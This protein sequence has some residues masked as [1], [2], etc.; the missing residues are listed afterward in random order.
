MFIW[1]TGW[2]IGLPYDI[3]AQYL[4]LTNDDIFFFLKVKFLILVH[5][6]LTISK[7]VFYNQIR[8]I[9]LI[10]IY[11][12]LTFMN[13]NAR[14]CD[15]INGPNVMLYINYN[16]NFYPNFKVVIFFSLTR[17]QSL[18]S[19]DKILYIQYGFHMCD[20]FISPP[21]LMYLHIK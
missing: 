20:R 8:C 15:I 5:L 11:C 17:H 21:C 3:Y 4:Y 14:W 1:Y 9:C 13:Y 16:Y 7:N 19:Y 10:Q 18:S 12:Y 6:I 2:K